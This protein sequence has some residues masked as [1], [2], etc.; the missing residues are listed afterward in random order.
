MIRRPCLA[1]CAIALLL[2]LVVP[3]TFAQEAPGSVYDPATGRDLS[4]W[5][6]DR[7]FDHLHML[8]ELDLPDVVNQPTA[9]GRV[10]L[11][12]TP[13]GRERGSLVLNAEGMRIDSVA[14]ARG[15][16]T[17]P[18][19]F[20]HADD[21]LTIKI[22]PPAGPGE[23]FKIVIDYAIEQLRFD[24]TGL[25][26]SPP[27]RRP[28]NASEEV[29]MLH[30]Q[31][32][33]EYARRWFPCHD[34]PNERLA[35]E[36]VVTVDSDFQTI[37]NGRLIDRRMMADGR[38]RWHWKQDLPHANYLVSLVVGKFDVVEVGGQQSARPG[39]DMPVYTPVGTA[40][41]AARAFG[42]T[43]EMIAFFERYFDEPYPWDKYAQTIV[44]GFQAGAMENTSASTFNAFAAA[45]GRDALEDII[46]HELVHQWTGNLLT[47]KSWEHLWLN[48]G[49]ASMGEALWAEEA[50]RLEAVARGASAEEADAAM[51][52]AYHRAIHGSFVGQRGGNRATAPDMPALASNR[53]VDPETNFM[54]LDNPYGKGA[55]VLHM[56]RAR[57]GDSIFLEG[58]RLYIKRHRFGEVE[59]DDLRKALEDV[60]GQSLERFFEQWVYRPGI[61]RFNVDL[62][63][64]GPDEG[65]G[66]LTVRAEQV[67][68]ID[69]DNPAY[70]VTLPIYISFPDGS[71]DYYYL[72]T[73]ERVAES[74]FELHA[75]PSDAVIDPGLH[76]LA[77]YAVKKPFAWWL[78]QL[79]SGPTFAAQVHAAE[80]LSALDDPRALAALAAADPE[81]LAVAE[82]ARPQP[83]A[84]R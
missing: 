35:T 61:A 18:A 12:V 45:A 37:S 56:L 9:M 80:H 77:D 43:P 27:T 36:L 42:R 74:A 72:V 81:V 14:V 54:K 50:A 32:Q 6:P 73:D 52:R 65:P 22:S 68:P 39:L 70:A 59:T 79:E 57:L 58:V 17:R 48:E 34:F 41:N 31:G 16:A 40:A 78:R 55:C 69:A 76:V 15:T 10:T 51:R 11:T 3:C 29:P 66:T 53:Y 24:G 46:A 2:T 47:C 4:A 23:T 63:W 33:P 84:A 75:R 1:A 38:T 8:L 19:A 71:G 64:T 83:A 49:W 7:H 62:A 26:W 67:Q 44:R 20:T 25:T 5:P 60:S 82:L 30:T 21:L 13:L 28:S